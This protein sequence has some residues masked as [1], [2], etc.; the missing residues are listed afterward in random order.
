MS[1]IADQRELVNAD[2]IAFDA[3]LPFNVQRVSLKKP[4]FLM[5]FDRIATTLHAFKNAEHVVA[6]GKFSLWNVGFCS[7][8]YKRPTMAVIHGTEVNFKSMALKKTIDVSLKRFG[9]SVV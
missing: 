8:F 4:R 9:K 5:Y 3:G 7:L 2:E 1:V 6:T